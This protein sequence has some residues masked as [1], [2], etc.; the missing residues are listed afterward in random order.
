METASQLDPDFL[1]WEK[2]LLS[3]ALYDLQTS[4]LEYLCFSVIFFGQITNELWGLCPHWGLKSFLRE[5][6]VW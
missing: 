3:A 6:T 2:L 5:A 1:L 4:P